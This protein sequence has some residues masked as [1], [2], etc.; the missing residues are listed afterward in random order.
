MRKFGSY[1]PSETGQPPSLLADRDFAL[2]SDG[3]HGHKT[4]S[5]YRRYAIVAESDIADGLAKLAQAPRTTSGPGA[6]GPK[7]A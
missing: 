1:L 7:S 5:V 6:G 2:H 3:D 4:E